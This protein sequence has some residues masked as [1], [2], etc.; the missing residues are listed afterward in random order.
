MTEA[1]RNRTA[2]VARRRRRVLR[3]QYGA[4]P[5]APGVVLGHGAGGNH[6][7][8]VPAGA[9]VR[10]EYRVVTWDQRGFGLLHEPPRA[11]ESAHR[12]RRPSR[13]PRSP[14]RRARARRRAVDGR[15][16]RDGPRGRAPRR[17]SEASCSPTRSAAFSS[18]AGGRPRPRVHRGRARSITRARERVLRAANPSA[19]ISTCRSAASAAIRSRIT[20]PLLRTLGRRELRRRPAGRAA[21]CRRCSSSEPND[22]IF[23]PA[24][25]AEAAARMPGA[26]GRDDRKAPVTLRTSSSRM[27]GTPW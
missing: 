6:G 3:D 10:A 22:E 18:R 4:D 21:G 27:R 1:T 17:V 9:R 7:D 19:R 13:D 23:P 15:L 5:T 11:R 14:R 16:G 20:K 2:V 12:N 25:I 26:P 24:W 8:L